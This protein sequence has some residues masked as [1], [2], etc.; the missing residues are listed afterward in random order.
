MTI[1]YLFFVLDSCQDGEIRIV[2]EI[3]DD[4][5]ADKN[6]EGSADF[7][8]DPNVLESEGIEGRIEICYQNVWGAIFDKNF[9]NKDAAVACHQLGYSRYGIKIFLMN[10]AYPLAI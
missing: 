4:D 2:N 1:I 5:D 9:T 8:L 6:S 10:F 7:L 3:S